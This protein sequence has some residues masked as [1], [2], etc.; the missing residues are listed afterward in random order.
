MQG[1]G[2]I[3]LTTARIDA[4]TV[5]IAVADTGCGIPPELL[6]RVC[7][8]FFT[9]KPSG[10]GSGLG[11]SMV[12]GFVRQSGGEL[13]LASTAGQG[14]RVHITLPVAAQAEDAA[15][16]ADDPRAAASECPPRGH[17]ETILAVDDDPAVL[18]ATADQL[19]GL[20]Y[21][22]L[23]ANHGTAALDTLAHEP[24][25]RLLYTDVVM[26]PPWDGVALAREA[27]LRRPHLTVLFTSGEHREITDPAAELLPKPVPLDRLA[28][29]VRRVLD[30]QTFS[31]SASK[32]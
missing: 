23:T 18:A 30:D 26:P 9:T 19:A 11:L 1:K 15:D 29:V 27:L 22:V 21:R 13:R 24:A 6:E 28:R 10:K 14:T 31:T 7:E 20:G 16:A 2:R 17:G 3:A 4:E 25:V 12:Y 32:T 8:P 5:E